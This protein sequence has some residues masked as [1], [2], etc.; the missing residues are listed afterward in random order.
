MARAARAMALTKMVACNEE[1][2]G[3]GGKIDGNK[4]GRESNGDKGN[5]NRRQTTINHQW[6]QQRRGVAGERA[7]MRQPH[8]HGGGQ[9]R[10][11][12]ACSR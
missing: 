11:M 2:D 6:D 7:S 10:T 1:G 12:I 5:G 8:D 3:D 9:R 4:G